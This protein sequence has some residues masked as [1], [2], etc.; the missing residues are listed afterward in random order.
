MEV[1]LSES[2]TEAFLGVWAALFAISTCILLARLG[3]R[4]FVKKFGYEDWLIALAG[5]I[6]VFYFV[7]AV[8][9]TRGGIGRHIQTL[10]AQQII[11]AKKWG[12]LSIMTSWYVLMPVKLS[13]AA[14]LQRL[15]LSLRWQSGMWILLGIYAAVTVVISALY[16]GRCTPVES[17]WL[18][19]PPSTV[20]CIL[21][22]HTWAEANRAQLVLSIVTD[23]LL[24]IAPA[25]I[26][27]RLMM[28][29]S[30]KAVLIVLFAL[31]LF[32]TIAGILK[33]YYVEVDN[34]SR[35]LDWTY[36]SV[37]VGTCTYVECQLAIIGACLPPIR[38]LFTR[39][40]WFSRHNDRNDR[41]PR[42]VFW[43]GKM[44]SISGGDTHSSDTSVGF[45]YDVPLSKNRIPQR[46]D[47]Q[48]YNTPG[49]TLTETSVADVDSRSLPPPEQARL[50][51]DVYISQQGVYEAV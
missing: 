27:A 30:T 29:T 49:I 1:N 23:L 50:K 11:E 51:E 14:Q 48:S 13:V 46:S 25:L 10:N 41:A 38:P 36:N 45:A 35:S 33:M 32:A 6:N 26:L 16:M 17:F 42:S 34:N 21:S 24:A 4:S 43:L 39:T 7:C 31:G 2:R 44:R 15:G 5:V 47:I 8:L 40:H 18:N 12:R 19:L 28:K 9:Q 3:W 20:K 22:I 37:L